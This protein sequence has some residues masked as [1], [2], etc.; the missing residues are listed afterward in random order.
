MNAHLPVGVL[1]LLATT[2]GAQT[3]PASADF[4]AEM[5]ELAD[6][7]RQAFNAKDVDKLASMFTT[8]AE[9]LAPRGDVRSRAAIRDEYR[10]ETTEEGAKLS[11]LWRLLQDAHRKTKGGFT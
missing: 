4:K 5:Q 3:P 1:L 7:W 8:D 10:K 11:A 9:L 2:G 6:D